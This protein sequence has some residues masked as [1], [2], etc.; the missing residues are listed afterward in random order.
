MVQEKI[1]SHGPYI[2]HDLKNHFT[3]TCTTLEPKTFS[4][5]LECY[6]YLPTQLPIGEIFRLELAENHD[7]YTLEYYRNVRRTHVNYLK[8]R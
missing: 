8:L 4:A 7:F 3:T 2:L 6:G 5:W 1:F